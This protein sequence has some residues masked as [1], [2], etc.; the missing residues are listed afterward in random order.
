MSFKQYTVQRV[1]LF[2]IAVVSALL[3]LMYKLSFGIGVYT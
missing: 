1:V 2:I 3:S